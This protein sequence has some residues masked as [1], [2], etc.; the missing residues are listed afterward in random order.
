MMENCQ[1]LSRFKLGKW[2]ENICVVAKFVHYSIQ[3]IV[4]YSTVHCTVSM[5][6]RLQCTA[7]CTVQYS[8]V[9]H[10]TRQNAC[11]RALF[12]ISQTMTWTWTTWHDT[13][14]NPVKL[15]H[16]RVTVTLRWMSLTGFWNRIL[17]SRSSFPIITKFCLGPKYNDGD[18]HIT[19]RIFN[20]FS[21]K[22]VLLLINVTLRDWP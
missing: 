7:H 18:N 6:P 9:V 20:I 21:Y 22:D 14:S 13:V 1:S 10:W 4:R 5:P 17:Y 16:I 19:W 2:V 12:M 8:T 11:D 3:Y 15:I